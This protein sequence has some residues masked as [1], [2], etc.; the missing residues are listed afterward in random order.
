MERWTVSVTVGRDG[1]ETR[2]LILGGGFG[3]V[4]AALGLER[5][6]KGRRDVAVTL[7]SRENFF[8]FYPLLPEAAGGTIEAH[9]IVTPLR[10]LLK[11]I[12][13]RVGEIEAIDLDQKTVAIGQGLVRQR[14]TLGYDQLVLALGGVNHTFGIPGVA[15]HTLP[16]R[17]LDDGF[18]IRSRVIRSLELAEVETD[19]DERRALL[20]FVVAGAGAT[21]VETAAEIRDLV[22]GSLR[23]YRTIRPGD[24]RIALVDA[25]ERILLEVPLQHAEHA[26]REL[27]ALGIEVIT[28][29]PAAGADREG[30]ALKDGTRIPSRTVVWAAGVATNPLIRELPCER[31]RRGRVVTDEY[32]AVPGRAGVW[33]LGDNA[34]VPL[35]DGKTAPPTSQFAIRQGKLVAANIAAGLGVGERR[36]F[37][38]TGLGSF[39][40]LGRRRA[41][42]DMM[43]V[44]FTGLPAWVAARGT[45][46]V[47]LPRVDKKIRVGLDWALDLLFGRDIA[48]TDPRQ[49]NEYQRAR[50]RPGETIVREG[51]PGDYLYVILDG[52]VEVARKADGGAAPVRL[53]RG[54]YFGEMALFSDGPR[55]ATVTAAAPTETLLIP[56]QDVLAWARSSTDLRHSF[57]TTIRRRLGQ[58]EPAA[59]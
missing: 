19:P 12:R 8:L 33:A 18:M 23:R 21:G 58:V 28:G 24:I 5:L 25:A 30:L 32:L 20:T 35:A 11:R 6:L 1:G 40:T 27:G 2:I 45:H 43:G 52:E 48:L 56:R 16:L 3:G 36:P 51:S 41:L 44:R 14:H 10:R 26:R 46:L 55:T 22:H 59:G 29:N 54:E 15:E 42:A 50:Y 49:P 57:E 38:F 39:V 31:D 53:G 13:V 34:A 37:T 9:H 17:S 47:W 7:V 4:Y